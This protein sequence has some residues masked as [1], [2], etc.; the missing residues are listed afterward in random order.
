MIKFSL[1]AAAGVVMVVA[2]PARADWVSIQA[3]GACRTWTLFTQRDVGHA[4]IGF[5]DG[6]GNLIESRGYNMGGLRTI[7]AKEIDDEDTQLA[8]N[9]KCNGAATHR[10]V[11]VTPARRAQLQGA[12]TAAGL[13]CNS[14]LFIGKVGGKNACSCV[15][16]ATRAWLEVTKRDEQW[17]LQTTPALLAAK[18]F[19]ANGKKRQIYVVDRP[20]WSNVTR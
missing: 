8:L 3:V 10:F 13:G 19:D 17:T 14:Y 1:L 16:F 5:W 7:A 4:N 20:N 15:T 9:K 12:I 2:A 6:N 11:Y 18:I